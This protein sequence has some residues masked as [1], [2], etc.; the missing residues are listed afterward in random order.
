MYNH[1]HTLSPLLPPFH[2]HM[3]AVC[4]GGHDSLCGGGGVMAGWAMLLVGLAPYLFFGFVV[5]W[6]LFYFFLC[7]HDP[8]TSELTL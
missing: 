1:T 7:K 6:N 8:T 5:T 4:I 2:S 3:H